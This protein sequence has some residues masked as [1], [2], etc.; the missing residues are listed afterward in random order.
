MTTSHG[1]V[2]SSSSHAA[3]LNRAAEKDAR[4]CWSSCRAAL[5]PG[6][7]GVGRGS[8]ALLSKA[9]LRLLRAHT[10]ALSLSLS[11]FSSEKTVLE[12]AVCPLSDAASS[13]PKLSS[14]APLGWS[15]LL[16]LSFGPVSAPFISLSPRFYH[17]LSRASA[18]R[19]FK[20]QGS[21]CREMI[22]LYVALNANYSHRII[23]CVSS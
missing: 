3:T 7:V 9:V 14:W 20:C 1:L 11:G 16:W 18:P 15:V 17:K 6:L 8:S 10:I 12:S 5:P 23:V 13:H 21:K 19:G 4:R 22:K 2:S